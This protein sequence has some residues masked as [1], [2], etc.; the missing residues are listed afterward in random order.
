M[1]EL[2]HF[3]FASLSKKESSCFAVSSVRNNRS[4]SKQRCSVSSFEWKQETKSSGGSADFNSSAIILTEKTE[5]KGRGDEGE[6]EN[7]NEKKKKRKREEEG[8]K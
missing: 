8:E 1:R 2:K 5:R 6:V 4:V 7:D 3:E